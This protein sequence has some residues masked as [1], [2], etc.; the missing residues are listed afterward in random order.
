MIHTILLDVDNTL[1]DFHACAKQAIAEGFATFHL[2]FT[3]D[4]FPVF[5]QVNDVVWKELE[6]G[7]IDM[8]TLRQTR[9]Q[10][11]FAALGLTADG[12]AF[13]EYFRACLKSSHVPVEGA[14][15]LLD[16]LHGRYDLCV[17]SNGPYNQQKNRLKQAGMLRYFSQ[18]FISE[19]I[20]FHKPGAEFFACCLKRLPGVQKQ[21]ILLIGDSLTAD[22]QG[23]HDFGLQT[24]WYNHDR[25]PVP[26][27]L[28]AM[29][30]VEQ[31]TDILKLF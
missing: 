30:V 4:V 27:P 28:P 16:G 22:M 8:E 29:G 7:V 9:F 25:L 2:P 1:L 20:G 24:L 23:G 19:E 3:G 5:T 26:N 10:R 17:A 12:A 21:E 13:E 31:L 18:L 6:Q 15:E 14:M 11:V